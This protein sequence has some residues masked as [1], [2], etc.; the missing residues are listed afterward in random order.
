MD[1]AELLGSRVLGCFWFFCVWCL[2]L[3]WQQLALQ[4][5]APLPSHPFQATLCRKAI[6]EKKKSRLA[7]PIQVYWRSFTSQTLAV[8]TNQSFTAKKIIF[9]NAKARHL[10]PGEH[11]GEKYIQI[12]QLKGFIKAHRS[13]APVVITRQL[14][15]MCSGSDNRKAHEN[16]DPHRVWSFLFFEWLVRKQS[17]GHGVQKLLHQSRTGSK[18]PKTLTFNLRLRKHRFENLWN[19]WINY[20]ASFTH[21]YVHISFKSLRKKK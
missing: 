14:M 17:Q 12:F 15:F 9:N 18:W 6:Q 20:I 21:T 8:E 5:D 13:E 1:E 3:N 4:A 16:S 7:K 19:I 10:F 11:L 2:E